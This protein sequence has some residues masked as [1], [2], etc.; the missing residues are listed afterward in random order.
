[1]KLRRQARRAHR[2]K[3]TAAVEELGHH[4]VELALEAPGRQWELSRPAAR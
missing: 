1:M 4:R 2:R 3:L